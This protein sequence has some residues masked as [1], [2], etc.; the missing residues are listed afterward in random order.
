MDSGPPGLG[1]AG[2]AFWSEVTAE[3]E[4]SPADRALLGRACRAL[5]RAASIDRITTAV[6][7]IVRSEKTGRVFANPAFAQVNEVDRTIAALL[8][9]LCIPLPGE[10]E[11]VR[12]SPA[13]RDAAVAMWRKDRLGR[14]VF[15]GQ[16]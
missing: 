6:P 15:N 9:E 13:Q 4:L 7:S 14:Q 2:S 3:F 16:A 10:D 1:E 5:D 11:G 12:R 8:R